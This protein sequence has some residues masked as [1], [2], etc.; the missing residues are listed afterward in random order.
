MDENK[1]I[2]RVLFEMSTYDG[3]EKLSD[4]IDGAVIREDVQNAGGM[5]KLKTDMAEI[6]QLIIDRYHSAKAERI[7]V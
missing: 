2:L 7:S 5:P 6:R 3:F 1:I 4:S